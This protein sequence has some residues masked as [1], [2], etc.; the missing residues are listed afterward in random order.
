[1]SDTL[2]TYQKN[3][4]ASLVQ[5]P[6]FPSP[7]VL[8]EDI[9]PI[10]RDP[11]L[12]AQLIEALYLQIQAKS[13]KPDV[14][15]GLDARGFLFGPSLALK[16]NAGFVPVRKQGKMPGKCVAEK[17][18]KEYGEDWFEMQEGGVS[19]GQKVLVV[20]DIIA[21]GTALLSLF[22]LPM[23]LFFIASEHEN[24]N[25]TE[26]ICVTINAG[27]SAAAAGSLVKK[28]G[29]EMLGYQFILELDFLKGR[30][31]LDAPVLTLLTGQEEKS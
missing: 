8:F 16:L 27:G 6:D 24:S 5:H 29:G 12:H 2:A 15:V 4:R 21:T 13:L 22:Q 20:D 23:I 3:L 25:F 17:Y 26:L 10:F 31:K 28:L 7:G 1:M 19:K 11:K 9:L 30:D 14:I 18:V